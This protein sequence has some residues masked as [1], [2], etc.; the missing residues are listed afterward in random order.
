MSFAFPLLLGGLALMA[1]PVLLHLIMRQKPRQLPFPAF[2][3]LLQRHRSNQRKLQLRHL[4]L[5]ALRMLLIAAACLALSRPRVLNERLNL[6]S[7]QPVAVALLFDNSLSMEYTVAGR[8]RLEDCRQQATELLK[9]LPDGSRVAVLLTSEP[10]GEWLD[11]RSLAEQ[12]LQEVEP[13]PAN[14]P[15]TS[16][17]AE[18]LRLLAER[19]R[20]DSEAERSLPRFLYIFCDRTQACWDANRTQDL[21]QLRE[22]S[23]LPIQAVLVD[24]GVA[25]PA[26]LA[27]TGVQTSRQTMGGEDRVI[28]Q[29]T[30][31]AA[32]Q[33][34]DT[35]LKCRI[36]GEATVETKLVRLQAGQSQVFVFERRGLKPGLHQAEI[37]LATGDAMPFDNVRYTTFQVQTGRQVLILADEPRDAAI[38]KLALESSGAYRGEIRQ[39]QERRQEMTP[40]DLARFQAICLLDVAAPDP[41][42]W[43]ILER[44]V[45]DGGGLAILPGG[46]ELQ[47]DA[48]HSEPATRLMP[49]RFVKIVQAEKE[50][51]ASWKEGTY[52]QP[53]LTWFRDWSAQENVDFLRYPRAAMRYWEVQ[54]RDKEA[55]V[56]VRYADKEQ[57][58]ALV[59]RLLDR[60]KT[61]G[62]VLLFTTP[63]DDR[64]YGEGQR[65]WND[66]LSNTSFYL[67]L[68]LKTTGYL[69]GDAEEPVFDYLSGQTIPVRLP[70]APRYPTYTLQGPG[71]TGTDS[72]LP[73]ADEQNELSVTKAVAPGNFVLLAGDKGRVAAF[74]INQAA[75]ESLLDK[76]PVE[77]IEAVLGAG[78]VLA[79][80]PTTNLREALHGHW[81]QPLE[82]LPWLL[83]LV[84]L[85][86]AVENFLANRFYRPSPTD[87]GIR[88][89]EAPKEGEAQ[90]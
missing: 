70:P 47:L 6:G 27:I 87:V 3:F 50:P 58:P 43:E 45:R 78:S 21:L 88:P 33:E 73:R 8:S 62:H 84:L 44:Y 25:K 66:Y 10:G 11:T 53:L 13:R 22:R 37:Y 90:P 63:M 29:A 12:R 55:E 68:A 14:G 4:V 59:E 30:V 48:Y 56:L 24:I 32:G 69:T 23:A 75:E 54:P 65:P 41:A 71:V 80:A 83:I 18:A 34:C 31:A 1:V 28:L 35:E 76:I 42:L 26:N 5:L 89:G 40:S 38:W 17:L 51:G 46:D 81:G 16:R 61:R 39:T 85:A 67:S 60:Q 72:V 86:L 82:L 7:D 15:V 19:D 74:S 77:Q 52:R 9:E 64:R 36:D 49:A 20:L 2:R 79:V 57:R